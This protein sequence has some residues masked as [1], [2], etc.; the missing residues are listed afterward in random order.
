MSSFAKD[1]QFGV[2]M[3]L[4]SPLLAVVAVMCLAIGIG[5]NT[6]IFSVVHRM[7]LRS[8]PYGEPEQLVVLHTSF[9]GQDLP[10][11]AVSEPEVRDLRSRVPSLAS[12]SSYATID[13]NVQLGPDQPIERIVTAVTDPNTF[14][15]LGVEPIL[16]RAFRPDE[17]RPG[18]EYVVVLGY[19]L[20][21]SRFGG[22]DGALGQS[23]VIDTEPHTIVGVAP[24]EFRFPLEPEA[25]MFAP[26]A[27]YPDLANPRQNRYL[28]VIAR[29]SPGASL[30]DLRADLAAL[31]A[32]V[33]AEYPDNYR[34]HSGF[35]FTADPLE[36][37]MLGQVRPALI[38]L[39]GAVAF[40]L[41]IAC[42]NV[43]SLLL[44]RGMSREREL[45][46]RRALGAGRR[47]LLRQLLTESLVLAL[48]GAVGGLLVALWG[49]DLLVAIAPDTLPKHLDVGLDGTVLSFTLGLA[50]FTGL[51]FGLLPAVHASRGELFTALKEGSG[52]T[53]TASSGMRTRSA[54]V[55]V[56]IALA[57]VLL[58]G[59]GLMTR[60]LGE[61]RSADLGFRTSNLLTA[62]LK[63]PFP[64]YRGAAERL[65]F[66]QRLFADLH[67]VGAISHIP[68]GGERA[69]NTCEL[70]GK[71]L[72]SPPEADIRVVNGAYFGVMGIPIL[73]GRS[74]GA[75]ED[76]G[77]TRTVI[78]DETLQRT[79]WPDGAIGK[80]I[81]LLYEDD[82]HTIVGVVGYVRHEGISSRARAQIY[83][84]YQSKPQLRMT[85]AVRTSD[86]DR[87][88]GALAT[89]VAQLDPDA[90]L[91]DIKTMD[92]RVS[93]ALAIQR[94]ATLLLGIF[95]GIAL[96]L[97]VVGVYA[98]QSFN[99]AQRTRE[100]GIR[101]AL[102]AR[103]GQV[104][105]M[106]VKQGLR[107]TA[108][109]VA[110][111]ILAS[112]AL[113]HALSNLLYGVSPADPIVYLTEAAAVTAAAIVAS[114]LAA[115]RATR[116]DPMTALRT[117]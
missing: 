30:D 42:A 103:P 23:V 79:Y 73:A 39:L 40:V 44:A 113:N 81:R 56:E 67:D 71:H 46:L 76:A 11:N 25:E 37:E 20:W 62:K 93:E 68:L 12:V 43:A 74:F 41:L 49:V 55:A 110:I 85:L 31:T 28:R 84:P 57:L 24:R 53:T 34:E 47:R 101:I 104:V 45:A 72:A 88:A 18:S 92:E 112:L 90:P 9:P 21:Q 36:D 59:A 70:E 27:M 48:C 19:D 6:A 26:L 33:T 94:F 64:K 65:A 115:R 35:S 114:F 51:L 10:R 4:K 100:I 60:S 98:V 1:A 116:I 95:A 61:M 58:I 50:L 66:Y 91:Y 117:D 86:P 107:I 82:W 109:G 96:L 75:A 7:L 54:L 17:G 80:R 106:I 99:V 111:G 89:R 83:L 32:A 22:D 77:D 5:A 8:L 15:T 87:I 38:L 3:L 69:S 78:V 14:D 2:R 52:L 108:A 29:R 105:A 97:A 63:L 13:A 102:G 16:G